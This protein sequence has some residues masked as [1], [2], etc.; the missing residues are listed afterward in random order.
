MHPTILAAADPNSWRYATETW[1]KGGVVLGL[2]IL[3]FIIG[4]TVAAVKAS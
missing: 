2:A 4:V 3:L 1:S